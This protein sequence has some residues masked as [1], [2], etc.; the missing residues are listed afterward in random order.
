M[1]RMFSMGTICRMLPND[2]WSRFFSELDNPCWS[3]D[4]SRRPA[5]HVDSILQCL[6]YFPPGERL[7]AERI[8]RQVFDLACP[9][10][11]LAL[12]DAFADRTDP[13]TETLPPGYNLYGQAL[14]H[15]LQA[16]AAFEQAHLLLQAEHLGFWRKRDDLPQVEPRTDEDALL[17]LAEDLSALLG[18]EEGRGRQCTVEHCRRLDGT[19]YYFCFPDDY[20]RTVQTHD[21]WG[22]L[23][24]QSL[25]PTFD[26]I[27]AY[28]RDEGTLELHA[29]VATKLKA[30]L[31]EL[32]AWQILDESLGPRVPRRVFELDRLKDREFRLETDP[33]DEVQ[34]RLKRLRLDLPDQTRITLE[35]R[36]QT[37][38]D[39]PW[40]I[41]KYLNGRQ[42]SLQAIRIS[43]ATFRF[44][45]LPTNSRS[46]GTLTFEV[47]SP[48]G[49]TLRSQCPERATVVRK[50]LKL[51]GIAHDS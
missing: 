10:G 15:W 39:I 1:S 41:E 46:R 25:L 19:D 9:A 44:D 11:R 8:L 43:S 32:F 48:N 3:M 5:R 26:I 38:E 4:W 23:V 6:S 40:L 29:Q 31:E 30:E 22:E 14:W 37:R 36:A 12:R 20:L 24:P 47:T 18:R 2:L 28:R 27:Y 33:A 16:P 35:P 21:E 34:A 50:H 49:C 42:I 13:P 45:F 51:W 7:R 17:R